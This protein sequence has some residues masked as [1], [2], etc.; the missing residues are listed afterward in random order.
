MKNITLNVPHT[1]TYNWFMESANY[2]KNFLRWSRN[3]WSNMTGTYFIFLFSKFLG[4]T[5]TKTFKYSKFRFFF[6][7]F[8]IWGNRVANWHNNKHFANN[9]QWTIQKKRGTATNKRKSD[10]LIPREK[11]CL[12]HFGHD[13]YFFTLCISGLFG[14]IF[15]N[16]C[17]LTRECPPNVMCK[18]LEEIDVTLFGK[19]SWTHC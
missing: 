13:F 5:S 15:S 6:F 10:I 19:L 2:W 18:M 8:R 12:V 9:C 4:R 11:K 14:D 1:H 17:Y 7:F 16:P 3:W